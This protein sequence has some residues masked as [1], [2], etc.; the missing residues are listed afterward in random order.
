[1]AQRAHLTVVCGLPGSGKTTLARALARESDAF[2]CN[3]DDW[4]D[5]LGFDLWDEAL[6]ARV[7]ALQ[8]T[9]GKQMLRNGIDVIVEWGTWGRSERYALREGARALGATVEL[10]FLDAPIDELWRRTS[11]RGQEDPPI[12][13]E[14]IA[15]WSTIIQRP[16]ADEFRHWS[17]REVIAAEIGEIGA[18]L[19]LDD[20][21][22]RAVGPDI[23][24]VTYRSN[25]GGDLVHRSSLWR[26]EGNEWRMVF[27]QGAAISPDRAPT[28][29]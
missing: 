28:S 20:L 11:A 24:F 13:R 19:P 7:E 4:F 6:R 27:H 23:A 15:E 8:W 1:M 29:S 2:L 22:V 9:V 26:R 21:R 17:R 14:Q 3:A 12:T 16:T 25:V 5:Q 10:I 18:V